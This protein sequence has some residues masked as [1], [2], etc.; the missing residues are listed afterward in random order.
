VGSI[1]KAKEQAYGR[2]LAPYFADAGSLFCIS[3]DFCHWGRRCVARAPCA[4][5]CLPSPCHWRCPKRFVCRAASGTSRTIAL[6]GTSRRAS[7]RWT[8]RACG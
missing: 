1:D 2:A 6:P 3:S 4:S 8:A 7:R 5:V